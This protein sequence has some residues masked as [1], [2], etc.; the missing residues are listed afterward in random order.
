M[1]WRTTIR[2]DAAIAGLL[3]LSA[4]IFTQTICENKPLSS[5]DKQR[6]FAIALFSGSYLGVACNYIYSLYPSLAKSV[7]KS[8]ILQKMLPSCRIKSQGVIS[9][10]ADNFIHVPVLYL[11]SYFVTVGSLQG[12]PVQKS[13]QEMQNSWWS[14]LGSCWA[15][16]V[17]FMAVNFALV[18]PAQ[19]GRCLPK[20]SSFLLEI[21]TLTV[22]TLRIFVAT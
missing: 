15:F 21:F 2:K 20:A 7:I 16:W 19:R 22:L 18:P 12:I 14:T 5:I 3:G 17:P 6:T 13:M 10:V 8:T 4:D 1:A 11:P 9:T